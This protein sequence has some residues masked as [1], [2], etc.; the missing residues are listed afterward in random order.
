M[1]DLTGAPRE[2]ADAYGVATEFWDWRGRHLAIPVETIVAVPPAQGV[3]ASS[4]D[5]AAAALEAHRRAPWTRMLPP[6]MVT[7]QGTAPTLPVQVT[8]GR[9]GADNPVHAAHATCLYSWR[10]PPRRSCRRMSSRGS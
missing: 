9:A 5:A 8:H 6:C 7:R 3:D 2:L 1:A 4:P 10:T